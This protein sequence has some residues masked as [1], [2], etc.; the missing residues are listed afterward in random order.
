[1]VRLQPRIHPL[2]LSRWLRRR[3]RPRR[4][5]HDHRRGGRFRLGHVHRHGHASP[6]DRRDGLRHHH[7]HER[8]PLRSRWNHRGLLRRCPL[9]RLRHRHHRRM[10]VHLLVQAP[11]EAQD[12]RRRR[13]RPRPLRERYLGLHRRRIFRRAIARRDRLRRSRTLRRALRRGWQAPARPDLRRPL[14]YR[15]GHRRHDAL[16]P[17]SQH[18]GIVPCGRSGGGGWFGYLPSQGCGV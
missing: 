11:R 4:R 15:V 2:D 1:M 5:H 7:V 3:L 10:G 14:D 18:V 9:G 12:R 16:L 17:S 6:T 13:C 8:R